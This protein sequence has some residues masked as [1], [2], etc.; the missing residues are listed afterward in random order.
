MVGLLLKLL[1]KLTEFVK[2]MSTSV[3]E[4]PG[5]SPD[6][7]LH[8][9][10]KER[11][12]DYI[13]RSTRLDELAFKTS[14]R[15]DQWVL[16]LSGGALAISLTF[17]EKIAPQPAPWT[18]WLLGLSWLSFISAILAGFFA[19]HYS[20]EAIYREMDIA[21][22]NYDA[23]ISTSTEKNL[24]GDT[25]PKKKNPP[26]SRVETSN[27]VSKW[28]LAAGT[29]L[30]CLFALINLI[31]T[32]T[33]KIGE[34]PNESVIKLYLPASV[35]SCITNINT[36]TTMSED[37]NNPVEIQGVPPSAP[38]GSIKGIHVGDP[39]G[40]IHGSYKPIRQQDAPPPP[41]PPPPAEK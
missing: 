7:V 16:T 22:E 5:D 10:R 36:R 8:Q 33:S 26:L 27:T 14:E 9:Y 30:L 11:Y 15:Y 28:C 32:K 19:I 17:L 40:E 23:F 18:L 4:K 41:P 2:T 20:R 37:T 25:Q 13:A 21:R 38:D 34:S 12:V 3:Q 35:I 24:Q 1:A 31:I 6:H 29:A 39:T